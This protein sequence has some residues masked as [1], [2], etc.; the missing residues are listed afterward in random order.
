SSIMRAFTFPGLVSSDK[1]FTSWQS[2]QRTPSAKVMF[3]IVISTFSAVSTLRLAA[4]T[5]AAPPAEKGATR[6]P[7]PRPP[8]PPPPAAGTVRVPAALARYSTTTGTCWSVRPAPLS[9]MRVTVAVHASLSATLFLTR[10]SVWHEAQ[11]V[12]TRFVATASGPAAPAGGLAPPPPPPARKNG[13]EENNEAGT[14]T[15]KNF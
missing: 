8:R 15:Q 4:L 14:H 13:G 5:T 9:F 3:C 2:T 11:T 10:S 7:P 6:P 1:S 12:V